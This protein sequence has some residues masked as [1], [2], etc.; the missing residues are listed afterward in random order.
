MT[1]LLLFLFVRSSVDALIAS[2]IIP[3]H[4]S[5]ILSLFVM[6][7]RPLMYLQSLDTKKTPLDFLGLYIVERGHEF[8][9]MQGPKVL[10]EIYCSDYNEAAVNCTL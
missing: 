5:L 9:W 8:G 3:G 6:F 2:A 4:E 7:L 1:L 10:V